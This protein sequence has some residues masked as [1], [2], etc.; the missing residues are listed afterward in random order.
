M[1]F[2]HGV[3]RAPRR[4]QW[5]AVLLAGLGASVVLAIPPPAVSSGTAK[6]TPTCHGNPATIVGTNG[7]DT[8]HKKIRGTSHADVI[9]GLAGKDEI[10]G[11][12]ANDV[13]CGGGGGDFINAGSG[14]DTVYGGGAGDLI[15]G[16]RGS[17]R[18]LG[19][20]GNDRLGGGDGK[21]DLCSGGPGKDL[22]QAK[23]CERIR[24]ANAV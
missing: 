10:V 3:K 14:Q 12:G 5:I 23:T 4:W 20:A 17:D 11:K 15:L 22:A 7:D 19:Q 8:G 21:R 18:L 9:A 6:A 16:R 24:G 13:I 1:E 2:A